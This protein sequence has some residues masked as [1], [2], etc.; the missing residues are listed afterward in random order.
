MLKAR[1]YILTI[2][3]YYSSYH[4]A[5]IVKE[6]TSNVIIECLQLVF[7]RFGYPDEVL[8]DNGKQLSAKIEKYFN[9]CGI[10]HLLASPYYPKTNG[11]IERFHRYFKKCI[12][13]AKT[14]GKVWQ[15]ELPKILM[16]YI[17]TPHRSTNKAPAELLFGRNIKTKLPRY[18]Q[19]TD[20]SAELKNHN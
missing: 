15:S 19:E 3:D 2:T 17:S 8:T 1:E 12:K 9:A 7:A 11:E 18:R 20:I 5:I 4:A 10:K 6:I 13:N 16:A 14:E